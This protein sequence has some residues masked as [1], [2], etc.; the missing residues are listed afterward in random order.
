MTTKRYCMLLLTANPQA[1]Q[2]L[3]TQ[4]AIVTKHMKED[5]TS[6]PFREVLCLY[7]IYVLPSWKHIP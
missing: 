7:G 4:C 5:E 2:V 1:P 3:G 6:S